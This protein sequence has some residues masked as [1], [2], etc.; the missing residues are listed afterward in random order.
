MTTPSGT[1][2]MDVYKNVISSIRTTI[3]NGKENDDILNDEYL[4]HK[5]TNTNGK[6]INVS[7]FKIDDGRH[8][9]NENFNLQLLIEK[10][11]S[12]WAPNNGVYTKI[13][14]LKAN[15]AASIHDLQSKISGLL[16]SIN[17]LVAPASPTPTIITQAPSAS[18]TPAATDFVAQYT[19]YAQLMAYYYYH[20]VM[21]VA[22]MYVVIAEIG[23]LLKRK[24]DLKGN[25]AAI[26]AAKAQGNA[27][28]IA[29][30]QAQNDAL[31]A[32]QA[33]LANK[34]AELVAMVREAVQR[35][36]DAKNK[37]NLP[38]QAQDPNDH[39]TALATLVGLINS[40]VV[41]NNVLEELLST[42]VPILANVSL[43]NPLGP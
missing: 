40:L 8:V 18:P 15:I 13:N 17:P 32:A 11:K 41:K 20:K 9:T 22:Y 19:P 4:M 16:S 14:T 6:T 21:T 36:Q 25:A 27:A 31:A 28:A 10:Y 35:A 34:N 29:A 26:A 37:C 3:H 12:E 39:D 24:T 33:D 43:T 38:G 42:T 1:G 5:G 30:A 7:V 23:L 2:I